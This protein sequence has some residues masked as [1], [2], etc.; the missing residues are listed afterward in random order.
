MSITE[1]AA[2]RNWATVRAAL[3]GVATAIA[4]VAAQNIAIARYFP[5]LDRLPTDFSTAY[6]QRELRLIRSQPAQT[7]F[8]GDSVLWGY[9]LRPQQTA[10]ALLASLG[11]ACR[12]LSFKAG[13]P[14]NY[15]ALVRLIEAAGIRP[16]VVILE[17][18]QKVFS[19][20]DTSYQTLHPTLADLSTDFLTAADQA[21]LTFP[22][23]NPLHRKATRILSSLWTAY[24]MR[25]DIREAFIGEPDARPPSHR[26]TVADF[27]GAYDLAPLTHDN[28]G[29]RFLKET[30]RALRAQRIPVIA[31][32]T[33]TN[34]VLLHEYIDGPEYRANGA[35]LRRL[36]GREGVRVVDLD[37]AIPAALF[38][39]N[40]HMTPQG[41]RDFAM[42][43]APYVHWAH[44]TRVFPTVMRKIGR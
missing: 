6:L 17:I 30:V 25:T 12:N 27:V 3:V 39:D 31:F 16:A 15:Y 26:P 33:P 18:N 21:K 37:H 42:L 2:I 7:I 22:E 20:T 13:S 1:G 32:M 11:C 40:D 10:V 4:I 9:G 14:P 35:Y 41:Q 34:H 5:Q 19:Q 28:V 23:S 43:L 38:Y 8:L 44:G 29:V 36:L 24:A